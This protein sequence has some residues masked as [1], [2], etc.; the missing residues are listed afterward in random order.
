MH[1]YH[2]IK[3]LIST[4]EAKVKTLPAI[5]KV[6]RIKVT[7]GMLKMVTKEH[8]TETFKELSKGSICEGAALEI[9]EVP[10]DVLV[11]ENI[12]GEFEE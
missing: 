9:T 1:E 8:F 4:I 10:G 12:E 6:T 2:L 11:V 5:K 3:P 7:L